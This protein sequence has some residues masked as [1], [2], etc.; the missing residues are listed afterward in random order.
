MPKFNFFFK[1]YFALVMSFRI[2]NTLFNNLHTFL[3][4][5]ELYNLH[6]AEKIA[7]TATN[8]SNASTIKLTYT[9]PTYTLPVTGLQELASGRIYPTIDDFTGATVIG[10]IRLPLDDSPN[11]AARIISQLRLTPANPTTVIYIDRRLSGGS[12]LL[13]FGTFAASFDYISFS[14]STNGIVSAKNSSV[15][16]WTGNSNDGYYIYV[17]A[18]NFK[19][20]YYSVNIIASQEEPP[21]TEAE[22]CRYSSVATFDKLDFIQTLH[23]E[24]SLNA[25]CY[26]GRLVGNSNTY[27][28]T[29]LIQKTIPFTL[30]YVHH[31]LEFETAT[32]FNT[33]GLAKWQIDGC[34]SSGGPIIK[35]GPWSVSETCND[36]AVPVNLTTLIV[37]N[38][39]GNV[40][41][42]GAT[43]KITAE[44]II[45][46][47]FHINPVYI[48]INV[49]DV[50]GTVNEGFG[51]DAFLPNWLTT[52]QRNTIL[53]S[54]GGSVENYLA[55]GIDDLNCQG[56]YYFSQPLLSVTS[57]TIFDLDDNILDTKAIG[58]D[59]VLWFDYVAQSFD[60]SG[61]QIVQDIGWEF[62]AIQFPTE[63]LAVMVT[64]I[65][66][67]TVGVYQLANLFSEND[68]TIRWN[69]DD[70]DIVGSNVWTSPSTGKEY[71]TTYQITLTNPAVSITVNAEWNEQEISVAGQTKYEGICTVTA[72]ILGNPATG[73]AW[74][75][76]QAL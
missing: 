46:D 60:N 7:T 43:Y 45:S 19:R 12:T 29:F 31:K 14:S 65:T 55:A 6:T 26:F 34:A 3:G 1:I 32:G 9:V 61:I 63:K 56:S 4:N 13:R 67:P 8:V 70:I 48:E 54:F 53:N 33:A 47:D 64:R 28:F 20:G 66:S 62:F 17:T 39:S 5:T 69:I 57:F 59:S 49:V 72:T 35:S 44:A 71:Y 25:W 52:E 23:P 27:A 38:T 68:P 24:Y 73:F 22:C 2:N 21:L 37:E 30:P 51:P 76:Q 36:G 15:E 75:E 40:G 42:A 16:L 58:N 11:S 50:L 41:E 74:I 18:T 10:E